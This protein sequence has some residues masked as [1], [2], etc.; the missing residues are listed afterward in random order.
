[1]LIL[2]KQM[3]TNVT[4]NSQSH[5]KKYEN[6]EKCLSSASIIIV[7]IFLFEIILAI[8]ARGIK[9]F[10]SVANILETIIILGAF[11]IE[12]VLPKNFKEI[13]S[14]LICT[15]IIKLFRLMMVVADTT[16]EILKNKFK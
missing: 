5:Q 4:K 8:F 10:K 2:E 9:Y 14:M 11:I 7:S 15:R 1:M 16:K 6:I 12:V 3:S 13:G